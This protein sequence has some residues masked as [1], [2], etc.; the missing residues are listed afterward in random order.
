MTFLYLRLKANG[1]KGELKL[2]TSD[3]RGYLWVTDRHG[4]LHRL[5]H[6]AVRFWLSFPHT[7]VSF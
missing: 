2:Q 4:G 6:K 3:V 7:N 1:E 5:T